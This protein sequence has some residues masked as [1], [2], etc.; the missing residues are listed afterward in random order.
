MSNPYTQCRVCGDFHDEINCPTLTMNF[1]RE[2][3]PDQGPDQPHPGDPAV[4]DYAEEEDNT[5]RVKSL[6]DL[7]FPNPP[8][9]AGQ[10]RGYVNQVLM[11]IGKLQKTRGSEVY[12]WAQECLTST[13]ELLKTLASRVRIAKSPQSLSKLADGVDSG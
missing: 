12:Q 6:N 4:R 2:Y 10:A 9:N 3:A 11:A 1:Y 5:I 8:E 13:E 7:V